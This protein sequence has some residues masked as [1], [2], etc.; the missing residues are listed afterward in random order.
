VLARLGPIGLARR[1][2]VP[3]TLALV[4]ALPFWLPQ[5]LWQSLILGPA[6]LPADFRDSFLSLV[7]LLD[8][9]NNRNMGPWL[10][11]A[12]LAMI[13]AARLRLA[14]RTWFLV[15]CWAGLMALQTVYLRRIT[16]HIPTLELS[17]FVWRLMLPTA[18]VA[19]AALVS[20]W[21]AVPP[22]YPRALAALTAVS[23]I[24]LAGFTVLEA[25]DYVPHLV[26]AQ[27][28][29]GALTAYDVDKDAAIWGIR[30]YIPNYSELPHSC[31]S[32]TPNDVRAARFAELDSAAG[33]TADRP[34]LSINRAPLGM[35][36]YR[37]DGQ[38]AKLAACGE[39]LVLGPLAS[40]AKVTVTHTALDLLLLVRG[41][42][43]AAL[44]FFMGYALFRMRQSHTL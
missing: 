35:V 20:R 3:F 37:V 23:V 28:D 22:L 31:F 8:P 6:A 29:R 12:V 25:P 36:D 41:V 26:A 33:A 42:M 4:L 38:P 19:F 13:V 21:E 7:E 34:Y 10:P 2:I 17:L 5:A 24:F 30:E 11:A 9:K 32:T 1:W 44:A 27:D 39:D 40:G 18:F 14:P 15:A 43:L 16:L